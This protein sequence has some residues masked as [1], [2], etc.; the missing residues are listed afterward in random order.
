[1][2]R[3]NGINRPA[4]SRFYYVHGMDN[5]PIG[6]GGKDGPMSLHISRHYITHSHSSASVVRAT[7]QVNGEMGN[8]IPC[9][10]QIP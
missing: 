6:T 9:H 2:I 1:M 3:T 5:N 10:A 4:H 8:S 7:T